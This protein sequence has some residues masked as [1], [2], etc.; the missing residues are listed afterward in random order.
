[1]R[2]LGGNCVCILAGKRNFEYRCQSH[3]YKFP[4][5]PHISLEH[6]SGKIENELFRPSTNYSRNRIVPTLGL[7]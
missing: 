6:Q 3:D 2:L 7:R 5:Y 1:M 4:L